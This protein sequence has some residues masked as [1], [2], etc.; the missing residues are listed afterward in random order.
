MSLKVCFAMALA[1]VVAQASLVHAATE[2][3]IDDAIKKGCDFLRGKFA[4]LGTGAPGNTNGLGAVCMSGLAMLEGGVPPSDASL[5]KVA[6][7]IRNNAYRQTATYPTSLCLI[8]L[9]RLGEPSDEALIQI[10]GVRLL[11]AQSTRGGWYYDSVPGPTPE[12]EKHLREIKVTGDQAKLHP[13]VE[14]YYRTLMASLPA[15]Q[16]RSIDDN[17]NTQFA[18]IAIWLSRKHGVPVDAALDMVERRFLSSQQP[19]GCWKYMGGAG[20]GDGTPSMY[21]AGLIGLSTGIAR[22][23]ERRAKA[24][25]KKEEPPM[26]DPSAEPKKSFDDPF[27]NPPVKIQ[28]KKPEGPKHPPDALDI[29]STNAKNGLGAVVLASA[30]AGGGALVYDDK[31]GHGVNDFYFYWSMERTCVIYGWDKLGGVDWH[32]A[33]CHTLV[34][35]QQANGGWAAGSYGEEVNTAF[36]VLFLCKSNLARDLSGKVQK[37]TNTEMRSS[38]VGPDSGATKTNTPAKGPVATTPSSTPGANDPGALASSLGRVEEKEVPAVLKKLRETR[39]GDFTEALVNAVNRVEGDR[40]KL[41]REALAERLSRMTGG[42]LKTMAKS[43]E[44]ELRRG[45]VLA[46]AMKDDKKHIPDLIEAILD[47]EDLV[48]RAARAGLKSLTGEDFGPTPDASIGEKKIAAGE[49]QKWFEK[50]SKK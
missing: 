49:W 8:F 13:D 43:D 36:A 35:K 23:E 41:A 4:G 21:C 38:P 9:D 37:D 20:G 11:V 5:K 34:H 10:L 17:S 47:E 44:P 12:Q 40:L 26:P 28:A 2:K 15:G 25:L 42:T 7:C 32:Q 16:D 19:S 14:T 48:V 27:F 6:E 39:G 3:E 29:A 1:A 24:P 18:V 33:G 22:R 30:R 45:A 31:G 46:M 50:Q